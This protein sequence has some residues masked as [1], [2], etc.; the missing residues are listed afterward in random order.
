MVGY[1]K[2]LEMKMIKPVKQ[3]KKTWH[4][5]LTPQSL[6]IVL[7]MNL[8]LA[9]C[10]STE[11]AIP[12]AATDNNRAD[13]SSLTLNQ[14]GGTIRIYSSLPLTGSS[15]DQSQTLVNAMQ[16]AL[17]DFGG[18]DKT[19]GGFKIE[20]VSLDDATAK[21]GQWDADQEKAN[22]N[23]A[24]A[25]L[26]AMVY[27][28]TF[29]SGAAKES[30]PILNQAGMAMISPA[31][32]YPGLTKAVDGVTD[33]NEPKK[34]YPTATRNYF[35]VVSSDDL[36]GPA[37]VAYAA[38]V[39]KASR[40]FLINDG[41]TYG[42]GLADAINREAKRR[43]LSVVGSA[44]I[45]GRESNY[46]DL[47]RQVRT[48]N[49]DFI[50][51]GGIAQQ[52][53]GKLLADIRA[54]GVR[55]PFMGGDGINNP[56]FVKEAGVAGEGAFSS[57][58]GLPDNQLPAKGQDFLKR[59]RAKYG[60]PTNYTIYGYEAM[61]VA[62]NA[63]KTSGKKDRKAIL[64]AIAKTKDYDGLVGKWSFDANGD[65]TLTDFAIYQ[66]SDGLL[67]YRQQSQPGK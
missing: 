31:N 35:R 61:A 10:G 64:D 7:L 9:A 59:Y 62:L 44:T 2:N 24:V 46:R 57:I 29:N 50:F 63:I 32:T 40:F 11:A 5:V 60:A 37:M 48:A 45:Q 14:T 21:A 36:Q 54:S 30:I 52:Q 55:A 66:I 42:K 25:D 18:A 19:V 49:P 6:I 47:A 28:G 3:T 41:Q 58:A 23:K 39:T 34:Y 22:A 26:D 67:S 56:A 16:M 1:T 51:F 27:L 17:D 4:S 15:K 8:L 38:T 65:T 53:P 13:S 20:Y 12:A 43:G 33:T